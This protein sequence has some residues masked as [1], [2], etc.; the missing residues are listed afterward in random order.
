M[1]NKLH[2]LTVDPRHQENKQEV[3]KIASLCTNNKKTWQCTHT[4]Q[5]SP[6]DYI[7]EGRENKKITNKNL[8]QST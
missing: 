8:K 1:R 5:N 3:T 4:P 6:P 2:P 7:D